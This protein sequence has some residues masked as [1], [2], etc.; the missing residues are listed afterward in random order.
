MTT[1]GQTAY[2]MMGQMTL[3]SISI[4]QYNLQPCLFLLFADHE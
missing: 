2:G 1:I 4:R 3:V